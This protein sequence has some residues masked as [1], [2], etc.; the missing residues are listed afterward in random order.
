MN[1]LD[2]TKIRNLEL[3]KFLSK[4]QDFNLMHFDAWSA[5]TS[6][7]LDKT[8]SQAGKDSLLRL[9][10]LARVTGDYV[11]AE[12]LIEAGYD[13]AQHIALQTEQR[14]LIDNSGLFDSEDQALKCYRRARGIKG[15]VEHF[16]ANLHSTVASPHFANSPISNGSEQLEKGSQNIPN[17]WD[18]FGSQNFCACEHCASIFGPAAYMLDLMRI[19]DDYIS[20]NPNNDIPTGYS[21]RERRPDLFSLPLTCANVNE[22]VKTIALNNQILT[23]RLAEENPVSK[24]KH[25]TGGSVDTIV[26]PD[27]ESPVN[28]F[29]DGMKIVIT[30][31]ACV[32]QIRTIQRYTGDTFTATVAQNWDGVPDSSSVYMIYVD[33]Y[34]MMATAQYPFMLPYNS[35][36]AE[37]R[38]SLDAMNAPLTEIFDRFA[39]PVTTGTATTG[40]ATTIGLVD[41]PGN[42]VGMVTRITAGAASG[43]KRLIVAYDSVNKSATVSPPWSMDVDHTSQYEIYDQLSISRETIGLSVDMMMLVSTDVGDDAD[44]VALQYGYAKG[45]SLVDDLSPV[46]SFIDHAGISRKQLE[47][48]LTQNLSSTEITAEVANGFFINQTGEGLP[49]MTVGLAGSGTTAFYQITNLSVT[50]LGRMSRFI[51]LQQILNWTAQQLQDFMSSVGNTVT[52]INEDLIRNLGWFLA[53]SEMAAILPEQALP[54]WSVM[55]TT[56]QGDGRYRD[57][58]FDRTF[59]NPVQ[60]HGQNPYISEENIPFDPSRPLTWE[61]GSFT[62]MNATI[63]SR[64]R[65]ALS[66]SDLD[67]TSVAEFIAYYQQ[68]KEATTLICNLDTLTLLYRVS[69]QASMSGLS[70]H[71]FLRL[72]W[73][74]Y[75]PTISNPLMPPSGVLDSNVF[76]TGEL[77]RI[78]RLIADS[79]FS[80]A[81]LAYIL[82]NLVEPGFDKGYR[83][84]QISP[85]I[86]SLASLS[87][88]ALLNNNSFIFQSIDETSSA[89]IYAELVKFGYVESGVTR[90][91]SSGFTGASKEFLIT[92]STFESGEH[93]SAQ[94]VMNALTNCHPPILVDTVLDG[95]NVKSGCLSEIFNKQTDLE[96]L[97]IGEENG[98]NLRSKT[99]STLLSIRDRVLFTQWSVLFP[100]VAES[101]ISD[102]ISSQE[103]S[104]AFTELENENVLVSFPQGA[105]DP[106]GDERA[107]SVAYTSKTSLDYLFTSQGAGQRNQ[108][109][110]Y[111]GASKTLTCAE[112][113]T[114][115]P[116]SSS[117][118]RIA[119]EAL[120]GNAPEVTTSNITL[121]ASA[122]TTDNAYNGMWVTISVSELPSQSALISSYDG[123]SKVATI[124]GSF[125]LAKTSNPGSITDIP[126]VIDQQVTAGLAQSAGAGDN[127]IILATDASSDNNAYTNTMTVAL[128]SNPNADEMRRQVGE[129]LTGSRENIAHT[130]SI[131]DEATAQQTANVISAIADLLQSNPVTISTVLPFTGD[132]T[133][134]QNL[135]PLFLLSTTDGQVDQ[136]IFDLI[137]D[138]SRALLLIKTLDFDQQTISALVFNSKAFNVNSLSHLTLVDI[139]NLSIFA[140]LQNLSSETVGHLLEYL[141]IPFG[142]G[143]DNDKIAALAF[144]MGWP[145]SSLTN[146]IE[147]FWPDHSNHSSDYTTLV[148][149]FRLERCF[150]VSQRTGMGIESLESIFALN[151]LGL[152]KNGSL[153]LSA[154]L[155]FEVSRNATLAALSAALPANQFATAFDQIS[156][157]VYELDR[158]ALAAYT[159]WV[160]ATKPNSTIITIDELSQFLLID[161]KMSGCD[162]TSPIAQGSN[163]L[164]VYLQRCRTQFETGVV[165]LSSIKPNWWSWM[166]NY[167][168]WEANRKIF[169]YPENY[170]DPTLRQRPS[171]QFKQLTDDLLQINSEDSTVTDAYIKY[172]D[173]V[174]KVSNLAPVDAFYA[175]AHDPV[176]NDE[177]DTLF[178]L[179]RTRS[180]PY[181]YQV[182]T[183]RM[184]EYGAGWMPWVPVESQINT[185][186]ATVSYAFNRMYLFWN[187]LGESESSNIAD[188]ESTTV[189]SA[190]ASIKCIYQKPDDSWSEPQTVVSNVAL[191]YQNNYVLQNILSSMKSD[192]SSYTELYNLDYSFVRKPYSLYIDIN[193]K[194]PATVN[195]VDDG[196]PIDSLYPQ[197]PFVKSLFIFAGHGLPCGDKA[198]ATINKDSVTHSPKVLQNV[199]GRSRTIVDAT[200]TPDVQ[201][202]NRGGIM[203]LNKGYGV[204]INQNLSP[205]NPYI[206][207]IQISNTQVYSY[208]PQIDRTQNHFVI[209]PTQVNSL[210]TNYVSDDYPG[211]AKGFPLPTAE[212]N[213]PFVVLNSVSSSVASIATI[214]N[215]P[216]NYLF[217]NG[218]QAYWFKEIGSPNL[219]PISEYLNTKNTTLVGDRSIEVTPYVDGPLQMTTLGFSASRITSNAFNYYLSDLL[220]GGVSKLLTL[221][222]QA[223]PEPQFSELGPQQGIP[224]SGYPNKN[225]SFDGA[226]GEYMWETFFYG[227]TLV[228]DILKSNNRFEE[229][230]QWYEYLFNPTIDPSKDPSDKRYWRFLPFREM[231]PE[232]LTEMLTNPEE[233]WIYNNDPFNPDAIARKRI[234]AFA[235]STVMRYIDNIISWG[236]SLFA[237]DTRESIAQATNF[238]LLAYDLLGPRPEVV[239]ECPEVAPKSFNDIAAEYNNRTVVSGNVAD[240]STTTNIILGGNVSNQPDA[241]TGMYLTINSSIN[242]KR[243]ITAYDGETHTACVEVPLSSAPLSTDTFQV[244]VDGIPQFLI[245][246]ENSF[247]LVDMDMES[248]IFQD[249]PYNM[250]DSYFCIPENPDFIAYWDTVEDRLSKIRHCLNIDGVA[251]PL[252]LFAPPI[253][254]RDLISAAQ[255]GLGNIGTQLSSRSVAPPM[256]RFSFLIQK[257]KA[258]SAIVMQFGNALLSALEKQDAESL[259]LLRSA[260]EKTLLDMSTMTKELSIDIASDEL[261]ALN[262]SLASA[263]YRKSHYQELLDA[264]LNKNEVSNLAY[265]TAAAFFNTTGSLFGGLASASALVPQVGSPFA[266]TYGGVQIGRSLAYTSSIFKALGDLSNFGASLNA[267]MGGYVRRASD[268]EFQKKLAEYEATGISSNI[269]AAEA[270]EALAKQDLKIHK[271]TIKDNSAVTRYLE[272][273]FTNTELYKWMAGKLS[274]LY[275]QSYL[276]NLNL[277]LEAQRS[278]QYEIG[279]NDTYVN[280]D[281]W[282]S[283]RKGLMAGEGLALS[284]NQ[285]DKAYLDGHKRP[286]EIEKVISL[287]QLEPLAFIELIENGN[288]L[289]SF[290][291]R[292]FDDDYPGHYMRLIKSLTVTIPA[293]LGPY[294]NFNAS[295]TQ[296]SNQVVL[297]PLPK[298]V[299]YLLGG[300]SE[301]PDDSELRSNWMSNQKIAV[302]TGVDDAGLFSINFNDERYLP[303]EG[304][305]AVSSWSFSLPIDTNRI[306][307][308][309]ISDVIFKLSYTAFDGGKVFSDQVR[310][311]PGMRRYGGSRYYPF[312]QRYAN[313]WYLFLHTPPSA[314]GSDQCQTMLFNPHPIEPAHVSDGVMSGFLVQLQ[315]ADSVRMNSTDTPWLT[316]KYGSD[317]ADQVAFAP[318]NTGLFIYDLERPMSIDDMLDDCSIVCNVSK[319]PQ[320]LLKDGVLNDEVLFD[321]ALAIVYE[322]NKS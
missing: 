137:R 113:W 213:S 158:N 84:S 195:S 269:S 317:T 37:T 170:L 259:S 232:T 187:E 110:S 222:N 200:N 122:S 218:D 177:E 160:I 76:S 247:A 241:Y 94:D 157:Q 227:P 283:S 285:L 163:S 199:V 248:G 41:S 48:L 221:G 68:Q 112:N 299:D 194:P 172:V 106:N 85:M 250:I 307:R 153:D 5:E 132:E 252:A 320:S 176:T 155:K 81:Q 212:H 242:S 35:P 264:G 198:T 47:D 244:F 88:G 138:L 293:V 107:L 127:T 147:L 126:F 265:M 3:N 24:D 237:I 165:D 135:L 191:S 204:N 171:P 26:L 11:S 149:V 42:V 123:D 56:G 92:I 100:I 60:L 251:R 305:G 215:Y 64:L 131:L 281:Y 159:L 206:S 253:N 91:N 101:F 233:I 40:S 169:L 273:K 69:K 292:L 300:T 284:L 62:G 180:E 28:N 243:V 322:G 2:S 136:K 120:N 102:L 82:F 58:M 309:S 121:D 119:I 185:P 118:Y 104:Q 74:L 303:F 65:A 61:Y 234:S 162:L 98:P 270:K 304:T 214:K 46:A 30:A 145:L 174:A 312:A 235:K 205:T 14:F 29:Y 202:G 34:L 103:S 99:Q 13:S 192:D 219:F 268:W 216:L 66:I 178:F 8:L 12:K 230:K 246:A 78:G 114:T 315:F 261:A 208:Q 256:Y 257:A 294:Q 55:T 129:Q 193:K 23:R 83:E 115:E 21:L 217:D 22:P 156:S 79:Q 148:G 301:Q 189:G 77:Y 295:L 274:T 296:A 16:S 125:R 254:P 183:Y 86:E 288:C 203:P 4:Q 313:Q 249:A 87:S 298:P 63:R 260:Q 226:F 166:M 308:S 255:S 289:F 116:D 267:T 141:M 18:I 53:F 277:A 17:Y 276:L 228:A 173:G 45:S 231:T 54:L 19:I 154:W 70:M 142:T 71:D 49:P 73:M 223:L 179:G 168:I 151:N 210:S 290:S 80:I 150:G 297:K 10:R 207:T 25:A 95:D 262:N 167:R 43:N 279:V 72:L 89:S 224:P 182:R 97:Y 133:N 314:C 240:G 20:S 316:F 318:D 33:P 32:N 31:G 272:S 236:D 9:Q 15:L 287:K 181:A 229:A 111:D 38:A 280:F 175:K 93:Y 109:A 117:Y 139:S 321:M 197:Y 105:F 161:I 59:N 144:A 36:L 238:Y 302:S 286:L 184:T 90:N 186:L 130:A 143:L 220:E 196:E 44:A 51:R 263:E 152:I 211:L 209:N 134:I 258:M 128:V 245:R 266:M 311:L 310:N 50:R 52:N 201:M 67:L 282:D 146:L 190:T 108:V 27:S 306:D 124:V 164:Q 188:N 96:F 225:V 271:Q 57:D 7:F 140:S 1:K 291:E 75:F 278:F 39:V 239:A 275:Y 6:E 319:A